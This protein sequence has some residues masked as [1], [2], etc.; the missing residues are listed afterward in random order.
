MFPPAEGWVILPRFR[1]PSGVAIDYLI[2]RKKL[3]RYERIIVEYREGGGLTRE[4]VRQLAGHMAECC[5]GKGVF[6]VPHDMQPPPEVSLESFVSGVEIRRLPL[7]GLVLAKGSED[8][9]KERERRR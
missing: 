5:A 9:D 4:D 8:G 1:L 7:R 6:C 2:Y 3:F